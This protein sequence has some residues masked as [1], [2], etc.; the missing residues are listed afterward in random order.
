MSLPKMRAVPD[1]GVIEPEQ[2]IDQGRLAGAVRPQKADGSP[3]ER[4][5]QALEDG[6]VAEPHLQII[7]FY[8]WRHVF[9]DTQSAASQ[10]A[11]F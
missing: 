4:A 10:F 1:G 8:D 9:N 2:R 3:R 7:Q 5:V 6:A 11:V